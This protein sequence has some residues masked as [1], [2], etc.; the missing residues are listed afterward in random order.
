MFRLIFHSE[1]YVKYL[2]CDLVYYNKKNNM[3]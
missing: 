3:T 2:F 1:Y